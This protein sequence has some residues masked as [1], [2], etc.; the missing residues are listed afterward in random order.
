MP[1]LGQMLPASQLRDYPDQ[2]AGGPI[3]RV[4]KRPRLQNG[5]RKTPSKRVKNILLTERGVFTTPLSGVGR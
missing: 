5:R 3:K 1:S 2:P 4:V